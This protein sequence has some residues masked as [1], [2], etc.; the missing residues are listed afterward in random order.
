M[1]DSWSV[2]TA[3]S[4]ADALRDDAFYAYVVEPVAAHARRA[5]LAGYFAAALIEAHAVG[6]V[7]AEPHGAAIWSISPG[8]RA[9]AVAAAEAV[10]REG[11]RTA[12]GEAGLQRF[13]AAVAEMSHVADSRPELAGAWY[14]SILGVSPQVQ[15]TG[16]GRQLLAPTLAEADTARI[17]CWLETFGEETLPFYA[18]LGFLQLGAPVMAQC[19]G[20]QYWILLRPPASSL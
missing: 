6:K 18:S 5:A 11:I 12:L 8:G 16:L 15:R 14:L 17:S 3:E 20:A 10:R 13:D 19:V 4:L 7:V 9:E 1:A 2:A